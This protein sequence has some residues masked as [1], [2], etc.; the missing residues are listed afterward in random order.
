M[1]HEQEKQIF[2]QEATTDRKYVEA[3]QKYKAARAALER[4]RERSTSDL[5][6]QAVLRCAA[7]MAAYR[8]GRVSAAPG[9]KNLDQPPQFS[10]AETNANAS[11]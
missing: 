3:V 10:P 9:M 8:N 11:P 1:V 7:W 2:K 4:S 5:K 6:P